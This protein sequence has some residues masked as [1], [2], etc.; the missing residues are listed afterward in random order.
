MNARGLLRQW[1]AEHVPAIVITLLVLW[2]P[3]TVFT[4]LVDLKFV[5]GAG[6]GYPTLRDPALLLTLLQIALMV[7]ALPLV[8]W[9]QPRGWQLLNSAAGVW[10]AYAVWVIQGR[11]RLIGLR[12]LISP[13]TLITMTALGLAAIV[14]FELRT[15][16]VRVPVY[17]P[18]DHKS[19][20]RRPTAR[21]EV[22]P[23]ESMPAA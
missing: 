2:A 10:L 21:Q 1:L 17:W 13:E 15:R 20:T 12:A 9:H 16:Y 7:A 8:A 11:L 4:V 23:G 14:L 5:D 19:A 22:S 6:S 3:P 18:D